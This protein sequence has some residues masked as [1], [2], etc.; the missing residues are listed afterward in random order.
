MGL[1]RSFSHFCDSATCDVDTTAEASLSQ[2]LGQGIFYDW[3][4]YD[5]VYVLTSAIFNSHR[6]LEQFLGDCWKTNTKV[7]T[8]RNIIRANSMMNESEFSAL[9]RSLLKARE[10]SRIWVR[11]G[12][13][14]ASHWLRNLLDILKPITTC[15]NRNSVITLESHLKLLQRSLRLW[16]QLRLRHKSQPGLRQ[17]GRVV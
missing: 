11:T 2:S 4:A 10:G 12:F 1:V 7:I 5:A 9:T 8:P 3:E 16:L 14:F 6:V 13:G 17:G 15:S